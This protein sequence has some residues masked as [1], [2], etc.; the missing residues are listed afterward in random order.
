V[1]TS[2]RTPAARLVA[3]LGLSLSVLVPPLVLRSNGA[4]PLEIAALPRAALQ[5]VAWVGAATARPR[6]RSTRALVQARSAVPQTLP[7]PAPA[8][9]V[10]RFAPA[11]RAHRVRPPVERTTPPA[12]PAPSP[13]P[14]PS[15]SPA[16]P[17]SPA[18]APVTASPPAPP[19][20]PAAPA[21][22]SAPTVPVVAGANLP[23]GHGH[24]Q[25]QEGQTGP[26][27]E[28]DQNAGETD[29]GDDQSAIPPASSAGRGHD[30][31]QG[32]DGS[33]ASG[34][35]SDHGASETGHGEGHGLPANPPAPAKQSGPKGR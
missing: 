5:T 18:P 27:S 9:A 21:A 10:V 35:E 7:V 22:P 3:A 14:S 11:P 33:G 25:V 12:P 16:P 4:Q 8:L 13:A 23:P 17:P 24:G 20:P 28:S 31:G 19:A 34:S 32:Q 2:L 26:G 29:Q 6:A 15:P 1:V 30:R